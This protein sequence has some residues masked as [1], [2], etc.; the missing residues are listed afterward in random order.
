M[1]R[2]AVLSTVLYVLSHIF[3]LCEKNDD[4]NDNDDD[5]YTVVIKLFIYGTSESL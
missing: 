3:I 1:L 2:T 4:V 5:D